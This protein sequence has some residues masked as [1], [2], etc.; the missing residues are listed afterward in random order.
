MKQYVRVFFTKHPSGQ[1][2]NRRVVF[3]EH[4]PRE[5][6]DKK[7]E[8]FNALYKEMQQ[9]D[10]APAVLDQVIERLPKGVE[11]SSFRPTG[12]IVYEKTSPHN[13]LRQKKRSA[14][15]S[16]LCKHLGSKDELCN[17]YSHS[18]I[19]ILKEGYVYSYNLSF[20]EMFES[21]EKSIYI[22]R[23]IGGRK[24][25]ITR[26]INKAKAIRS[27]YRQTLFPDDYTNDTKFIAVM[28]SLYRKRKRL[29]DAKRVKPDT[30]PDLV[31]EADALMAS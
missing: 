1:N 4:L 20:A 18:G 22:K 5:E 25:A 27:A 14:A 26:S 28:K 11:P 31:H 3:S 19:R 29:L 6:Y 2:D 13:P 9:N 10:L 8:Q 15:A 23:K 12:E 30:L 16:R 24:S 17:Y 7:R 21:G